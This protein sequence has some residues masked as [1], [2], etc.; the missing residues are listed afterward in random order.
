LLRIFRNRENSTKNLQ[1]CSKKKNSQAP[2]L[3]F[4][5]CKKK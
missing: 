1:F 4:E 2:R 5:Q 3:N